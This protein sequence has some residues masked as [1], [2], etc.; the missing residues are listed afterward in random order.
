MIFLIHSSF[1]FCLDLL[2]QLFDTIFHLLGLYYASIRS[3]V[4]K[5]IF[6]A[7]F[8]MELEK[9]MP[10]SLNLVVCFSFYS[11]MFWILSFF[12]FILIGWICASSS[13]LCC[14]R[15][16]MK[17]IPTFL[18]FP[19]YLFLSAENYALFCQLP[20]FLSTDFCL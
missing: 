9:S 14:L 8:F 20:L 5:N 17:L 16:K 1:W 12:I 19:F 13:K 4:V 6:S 15:T 2:H 3:F 7:L 18:F 11:D 10:S